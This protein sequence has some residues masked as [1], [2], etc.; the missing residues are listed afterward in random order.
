[1][2]RLRAHWVW[3]SGQALVVVAFAFIAVAARDWSVAARV[4]SAVFA[5]A[6]GVWVIHTWR[7]MG[8]PE[9]RS[10]SSPNDAAQRG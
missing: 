9:Q 3:F 1:M 4:G 7:Q 2:R 8:D 10:A 5:V 6:N